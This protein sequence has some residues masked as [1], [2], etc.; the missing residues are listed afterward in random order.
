MSLNEWFYMEMSTSGFTGFQ[1]LPVGLR[2]AKRRRAYVKSLIAPATTLWSG[3][4]GKETSDL[5]VFK[6]NFSVSLLHVALQRVPK[7]DL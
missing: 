3:H 5:L 2:Y 6:H 4:K 7:F 1:G